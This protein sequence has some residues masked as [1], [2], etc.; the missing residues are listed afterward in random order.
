M[1]IYQPSSPK[2]S[3]QIA[4]GKWSVHV[5]CSFTGWTLLIGSLLVWVHPGRLTWNM[6]MEVW[7]MIFL[8]EWVIC[9]FH[10]N[11]PGCIEFFWI[12]GLEMVEHGNWT[13]PG[14]TPQASWKGWW[15]NFQ[16]LTLPK[17]NGWKLTMAPFLHRRLI[18]ESIILRF[19]VWGVY[20]FIQFS[21]VG[22]QSWGSL[23]HLYDFCPSIVGE[24]L[25][26]NQYGTPEK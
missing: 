6:I 21:A 5:I 7:K 2:E 18:L 16:F 23:L 25:V 3:W 19:H 17:F 22:I 13:T 14:F 12:P 20:Q 4:P 11:L 24:T 9:R 1:C 26:A 8:Y 10:V 15:R